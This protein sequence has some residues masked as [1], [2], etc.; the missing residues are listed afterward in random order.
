MITALTSSTSPS[1][2]LTAL[3]ANPRLTYSALRQS[4]SEALILILNRD[5]GQGLAEL[6]YKGT[7]ILHRGRLLI[8]HLAGIADD[9]TLHRLTLHVV[10]DE[11]RS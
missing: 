7:D 5:G 11:A 8:V 3:L 2:L 4:R 1:I 10:R 9:D 6:L